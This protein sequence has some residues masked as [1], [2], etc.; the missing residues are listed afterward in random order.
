MTGQSR[1]K[2]IKVN[3]C[4]RAPSAMQIVGIAL[5]L[6]IIILQACIVGSI[7]TIS[8]AVLTVLMAFS[9]LLLAIIVFDYVWLVFSDPVDPRLLDVP[10]N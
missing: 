5:M 6:I 3:G 10:F 7:V 9:Y 1:K 4:S 2:Y 8:N